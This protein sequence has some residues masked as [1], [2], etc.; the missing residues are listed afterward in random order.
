MQNEI[1]LLK[2][3]IETNYS[4]LIDKYGD[5]CELAIPVIN[6]IDIL[7]KIDASNESVQEYLCS[8]ES[9]LL[10]IEEK[11]QSVENSN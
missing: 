10:I 7:I 5:K 1:K 11:L 4:K 9:S 3:R 8:I 6:M 2:Y